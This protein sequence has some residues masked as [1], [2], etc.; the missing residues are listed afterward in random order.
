M[1]S[2]SK[3]TPQPPIRRAIIAAIG[4]LV[5]ALT[6]SLIEPHLL[7]IEHTELM[8]FDL[9]AEFDGAR[10]VYAS[11]IH[12]GS[13][14]GKKRIN[15]IID[16]ILA[17]KPDLVLLGGDY[18]DGDLLNILDTG[19]DLLYPA[20]EQLGEAPLGVIGVLG[21]HDSGMSTYRDRTRAERVADAGITVLANNNVRVELNGASIVVAGT[22]DLETG[23]PDPEAAAQGISAEEFAILLSHNPD[24]FPDGL[25]ATRDTDF[26]LALAGHT[27]GGQVTF[28]GLWAPV[29]PSRYG[30][31]FRSGWSEVEGTPVLV[32]RGTGVFGLP[33]RFFAPPQVHV[34]TLRQK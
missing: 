25:A 1:K 21:N 28:F 4:A 32:S 31:R 7:L 5:L 2:H 26:D 30:Q 29:I 3:T 27:H 16:T 11:D 17:E 15:R 9:P 10:I 34:I 12:A 20:I 13:L 18:T 33:L 19:D 24:V 23:H 6:W 22:E 8:S 14:L